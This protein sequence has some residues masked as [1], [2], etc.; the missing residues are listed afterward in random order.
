MTILSVVVH[1]CAII[2]AHYTEKS[3]NYCNNS[4]PLGWDATGSVFLTPELSMW[5]NYTTYKTRSSLKAHLKKDSHRNVFEYL[6]QKFLKPLTITVLAEINY[7]I[8]S[9]NYSISLSYAELDP[10]WRQIY[11][12][13]LCLP[14]KEFGGRINQ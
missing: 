11:F 13:T 2:F 12:C 6:K 4:L 5:Q 3:R 1:A 9:I 10:I 7:L 8:C 14:R